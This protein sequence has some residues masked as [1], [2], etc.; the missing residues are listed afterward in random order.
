[1]LLGR[2]ARGVPV[3]LRSGECLMRPGQ[4]NDS[5]YLICE[6]QIRIFLDEALSNEVA[7][8]GPGDSLGEQSVLD[9]QRGTVYVVAGSDARLLK[10]GAGDYREM[11][12]EQPVIAIN[13]MGILT[14][15]VR[16]N[17]AGLREAYDRQLQLQDSASSDSLTGLHN[18]RWMEEMFARQAGRSQRTGEPLSLILLDLDH[19]KAVND[20]Y[21]HP[22]GDRLLQHFA[23]LIQATF[24]P[25]DLQVRYGG[26]EFCIM[27]PG[28]NS[29]QAIRAA[30]RLGAAVH[31]AP[32]NLGGG[33]SLAF[34]VSCGVAEHAPDTTV[35]TL[36]ERADQALYSAKRTGRDKAVVWRP[37]LD[38]RTTS[39]P[40]APR[41]VADRALAVSAAAG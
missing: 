7:C 18:R 35:A 6:G 20:T 2:L 24:R 41:P 21:G 9:N 4:R 19:F 14:E 17:N 22:A 10:I 26:E 5:V 8:I 31:A 40:P 12:L 13:V 36:I 39:P 11:I 33:E 29:A 3:D 34:T 32:L 37:E 38:N 15:R 25:T 28:A 23:K 1:M 27:L 30:E 16:R